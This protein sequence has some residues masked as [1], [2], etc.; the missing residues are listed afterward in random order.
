MVSE[1]VIRYC[2]A[3]VFAFRPTIWSGDPPDQIKPAWAAVSRCS[4][5]DRS[6]R[7]V[8]YF[9]DGS[10]S[11]LEDLQYETLEIAIDQAHALA[12]VPAHSWQTCIAPVEE[13]DG[14]NVGSFT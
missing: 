2:G 10:G 1:V 8:L 7:F 11:V 12:G 4:S 3:D 14:I 9:L 6:E 5:S 13:G